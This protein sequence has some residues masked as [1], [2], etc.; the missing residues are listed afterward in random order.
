[1]K[2]QNSQGGGNINT[3][4]YLTELVDRYGNLVYSICFKITDSYFD[5]QDLTQETFLSVYRNLPSFDGTNEKAWISRIATNKCLDY[6]K[7]AKRRSMPTEDEYFKQIESSTPTPEESVLEHQVKEELLHACNNLK[8]PY[9]KIAK[10]YF[11]HEMTM[12]EIARETGK[13][14]KTVQTQ[15]YRAKAL[16]KKIWRKEICHE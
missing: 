7:S 12:Q 6:V 3:K 14:I 9:D 5:A 8:P 10:D 11:Y 2:E 1:M 15:V 16:L 13:N 4:E